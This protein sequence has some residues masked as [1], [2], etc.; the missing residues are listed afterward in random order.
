MHKPVLLKESLE[1]L[2][3]EKNSIVVDA[4]LGGGGHSLKIIEKLGEK[5]IFIGVDVD[6]K[7]IR[8]FQDTLKNKDYVCRVILENGNFSD[9]DKILKKSGV[10]GV[11]AIL[12]DLGWRSQQIENKD[13][14]FSFIMDA[15]L[16]MRLGKRGKLTAKEIINQ[17]EPAKIEKIF[18]DFGEEKYAKKAAEA[19]GRERNNREIKTTGEL[20]EIIKKSIGKYYKKEKIHPATRIFQALR[21]EVNKELECLE[22]FLEK[23][24]KILNPGGRLAVI[25]FHSLEDRIVKIFFRTN[26]RGCIC[27]KELPICVCD[28]KPLLKTINRKPVFPAREEIEKNRRARSAKLRIAE[29]I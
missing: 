23:S 3:L 19:I 25:S 6:K 26:A 15:P 13:Y 22:V 8:E 21:I 11:D 27:P 20:A 5:G 9:L 18:R 16:D 7:A 4:T 24:L 29:K 28:R 17:W 2:K 14:G 1:G 12:A 10:M